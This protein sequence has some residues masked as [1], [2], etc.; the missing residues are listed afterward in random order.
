MKLFGCKHDWIT[1]E[2][3]WFSSIIIYKTRVSVQRCNKCQKW[4]T[5][6]EKIDQDV[7]NK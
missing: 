4:Q 5:V 7:K 6:E 1:K 2:V 3:L